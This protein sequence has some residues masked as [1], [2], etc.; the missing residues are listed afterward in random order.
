MEHEYDVV[1]TVKEYKAVLKA[2][3]FNSHI[4]EGL[5]EGVSS[6]AQEDLEYA[7]KLQANLDADYA[8]HLQFDLFQE[9]HSE[10][11]S[12]KVSSDDEDDGLG[13]NARR[14]SSNEEDFNAVRP[15]SSRSATKENGGMAVVDNCDAGSS[16]RTT[17]HSASLFPNRR[18]YKP[19]S[20][21]SY[22]E[23]PCRRIRPGRNRR[24]GQEKT[25]SKTRLQNHPH[26]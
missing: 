26:Q 4:A 25:A 20:S 2:W 12:V 24:I 16:D 17:Y 14:H 15:M 3:G 23:A 7:R 19:F 5:V 8:H 22:N 6:D 13:A 10:T 1:A 21:A 9:E 11:E 18:P